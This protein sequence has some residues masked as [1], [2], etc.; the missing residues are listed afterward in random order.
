MI[1][2]G[3]CAPLIQGKSMLKT[4]RLEIGSKQVF[5]VCVIIHTMLNVDVHVNQQPIKVAVTVMQASK[6]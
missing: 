4:L 6:Q 3:D 5:A 1:S 2:V